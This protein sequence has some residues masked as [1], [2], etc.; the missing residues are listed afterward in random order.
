VSIAL[1]VSH[2]ARARLRATPDQLAANIIHIQDI[3]HI[4][5]MDRIRG[6]IRI[7]DMIHIPVIDFK[8]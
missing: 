8:S 6:M 3:V 4:R 5:D 1:A 2:P 7:L